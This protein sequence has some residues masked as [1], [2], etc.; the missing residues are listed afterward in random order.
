MASSVVADIFYVDVDIIRGMMIQAFGAFLKPYAGRLVTV[1][2]FLGGQQIGHAFSENIVGVTWRLVNGFPT[3]DY[4]AFWRKFEVNHDGYRQWL[5]ADSDEVL[6]A[7]EV[8]IVAGDVVSRLRAPSQLYFNTFDGGNCVVSR[9][10]PYFVDGYDNLMAKATP[11]KGTSAYRTLQQRR[12]DALKN[13]RV[14]DEWLEECHANGGMRPET[15]QPFV[16]QLRITLMIQR[17]I[18]GVNFKPLLITHLIPKQS[19]NKRFTFVNVSF[20]HVE[21]LPQHH[22]FQHMGLYET[23]VVDRLPKEAMEQ[24]RRENPRL[25]YRV[26][27]SGEL[28]QILDGMKNFMVEDPM[29][30]LKKAFMKDGLVNCMLDWKKLPELSEFILAGTHHNGTVEGLDFLD[31][32]ELELLG[33]TNEDALAEWTAKQAIRDGMQH[34]DMIKAYASFYKLKCADGKNLLGKITDF[35]ETSEMVPG[36]KGLYMAQLDFSTATFIFQGWNQTLN[37]PFRTNTVY[38]S[39]ELN[40]LKTQGVKVSVTFGCWGS[41]V[42]VDF[43]KRSR[44]EIELGAAPGMLEK[45]PDGIRNYA[46]FVGQCQANNPHLRFA[47]DVPREDLD[48]FRDCSRDPLA[49]GIAVFENG[50]VFLTYENSESP[51]MCHITAQILA[52]IRLEMFELCMTF[53]PTDLGRICSDGLYVKPSVNLVFD[54]NI[55]Q[56]KTVLKWGNVGGGCYASNMDPYLVPAYLFGNPLPHNMR[57]LLTGPGGSGK[58]TWAASH[59]YIPGKQGGFV[60]PIMLAHSIALREK[61][62]EDFPGVDAKCFQDVFYPDPRKMLRYLKNYNVLIFDEASMITKGMQELAERKYEVCKL[63]FMGDIGYQASPVP[64]PHIGTGPRPVVEEFDM[65]TYVLG[66]NRRHFEHC[67]RFKDALMQPLTDK[68]RRLIDLRHAPQTAFQL[69]VDNIPVERHVTLDG[70]KELYTQGDYLITRRLETIE[71][72]TKLLGHLE[73]YK[74]QTNCDG[75]R[76]GAIVYKK[77]L[78]NVGNKWKFYQLQHGMTVHATQGTTVKQPLKLFICMQRIM[79]VR[80]LYTA[81]SRVQ[82]L[83]QVYLVF[84]DGNKCPRYNNENPQSRNEPEVDLDYCDAYEQVGPEPDMDWNAPTVLEGFF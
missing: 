67:Y 77:P 61:M 68:F 80:V 5:F 54:S 9:I 64:P 76:K 50:T 57:E 30:E 75:H 37:F 25:P 7:D 41:D 19:S 22:Q 14:C 33:A 35:R 45:G 51:H 74:L 10:K 48:V 72:Y 28:V 11:K 8:R 27:K 82:E 4:A 39:F 18:Q 12:S 43:E 17:P 79:E 69:L 46:K 55:F 49:P 2:R 29:T 65:S 26:N 20:G 53:S 60:K 31:M 21:L 78:T 52:L 38:T 81:L 24:K 40:W 36:V 34:V 83:A 56:R 15:A 58:T 3:G 13:L 62:L 44:E 23:S 84:H 66:R 32:H 47:L 42:V 59:C 63:L 73:R 70:L 71:T 1:Q 6:I 16:D